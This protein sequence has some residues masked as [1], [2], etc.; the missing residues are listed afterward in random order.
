MVSGIDEA[1]LARSRAYKR[2][3]GD[4]RESPSSRVIE[5]LH[6]LEA[7]VVVCD[8]HVEHL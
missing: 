4:G 3:T 6:H 7:D 8:P 1:S 5:L 2:N